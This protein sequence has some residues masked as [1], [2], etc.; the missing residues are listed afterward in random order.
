MYLHDGCK[1]LVNKKIKNL[2]RKEIVSTVIVLSLMPWFPI[3][4]WTTRGPHS[5]SGIIYITKKLSYEESWLIMKK[6][7]QNFTISFS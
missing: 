5:S 2:S 3:G 6:T 1:F 7:Y 4:V